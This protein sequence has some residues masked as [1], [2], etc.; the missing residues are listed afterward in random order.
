MIGPVLDDDEELE[1]DFK[2]CMNYTVTPDEFEAKWSAMITK[3]NLQGNVHFHHLYGM[4]SSFVP[5][6]YMHCF[7][8]FCNQL[9]RVRGLMLF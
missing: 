3:Y 8:P 2:E 1:D 4:R 5:A 6:C 7:Y 9:S